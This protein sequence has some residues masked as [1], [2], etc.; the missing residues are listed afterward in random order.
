MAAHYPNLNGGTSPGTDL[1]RA[2]RRL[3]T[4]HAEEL[5][6]LLATRH[7]QTNEVGR[8]ALF[9]PALAMIAEHTD[10]PLAQVDVG[11][12]AGLTLLWPHYGYRFEPGPT[13]GPDRTVLLPCGVRGPAP[14][15][16]RLPPSVPGVGLDLHPI[17]STD[18]D[19][20]RWLQACVWPD[21]A[22]RFHRLH[23]ALTLARTSP[24]LVRC[25]D[26]VDDVASLVLV[27]ARVGHPVVTTSW[28]L[29]YL[30]ANRQEQFAG[31]LDTLG[32]ELDLSWVA[33]ESP[34]Q[35][36]GLAL[37]HPPGAAHLTV[38]TLRTW[39]SGSVHTVAL[40]TA[41]PHGYWLHWIS[42]NEH[43]IIEG[44]QA[45]SSDAATPRPS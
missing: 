30:A 28:A 26:A 16:T 5:R 39:R 10:E 15:P 41:H 6:E 37:P 17:D 23:S 21:Q 44:G 38:L 22:D 34:Q 24:P 45:A 20:I 11:S 43:G 4:D 2:F 29:S 32:K 19:A 40:A 3:C 14:L 1:W 33:A 12:S 8:C 42:G 13:L 25:G 35:T 9:L 31:V 18:T 27:A 7:T 36:P